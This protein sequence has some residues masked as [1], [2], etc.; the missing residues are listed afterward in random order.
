[1]S[2]LKYI[3]LLI[4]ILILIPNISLGESLTDKL[5]NAVGNVDT[6]SMA[7]QNEGEKPNEY[8]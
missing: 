2:V 5:S 3:S 7:T 6:S 8:V 1:M 4:L